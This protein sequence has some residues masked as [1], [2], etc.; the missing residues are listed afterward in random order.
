MKWKP[1]MKLT[2]QTKPLIE[3]LKVASAAISRKSTLPQLH[4]ALVEGRDG[5]LFVTCD[6]LDARLTVE[7]GGI[8]M[9]EP[10]SFLVAPRLMTAA[11]RDEEATIEIQTGKVVIQSGGRTVLNTLPSE[12]FP[13][14]TNLPELETCDGAAFIAAIKSVI[15]CV[16]DDPTRAAINSAFYH[17]SAKEIVAT[18]GT[19]L[20]L[21]P[22]ELPLTEDAIIPTEVLHIITSLDAEDMQIGLTAPR[23]CVTSGGCTLVA[24]MLDMNYPNYK[25][26]IP[27]A[28]GPS[29]TV[30]RDVLED[31]LS[32]V[33]GFAEAGTDRV[34]AELKDGKLSLKASSPNG[35]ESRLDIE[36]VGMA[37]PLAFSHSKLSKVIHGWAADEVKIQQQDEISPLLITAGSGRLG[38]LMPLRRTA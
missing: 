31:A 27:E 29:F 7:A 30:S 34:N 28:K 32:F 3:A 37:N 9:D 26:V 4:C 23:L 6:N 16:S 22:C 36:A 38:V 24:K 8:E 13:H 10:F 11:L 25:Q 14:A 12:E 15:G 33:G 20:A 2:I 35:N 1:N 5:K 18:N 19:S 21:S 17:S